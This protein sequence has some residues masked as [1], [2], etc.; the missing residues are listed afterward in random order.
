MAG[1]LA[2]CG[3]GGGSSGNAFTDPG[4][5]IPEAAY[6]ISVELLDA[7][8]L[9]PVQGVNPLE[10]VTVRIVVREKNGSPVASGI[11]SVTTSLGALTP[12]SG[13][14]LTNASGEATIQLASG[15]AAVGSAGTLVVAHDGT[16]TDQEPLEPL[17]FSILPPPLRLGYFANGAFVEGTVEVVAPSLSSSG[18][19][20]LN[21]VVLGPDDQPYEEPLAVNFFSNCSRVNPPLAVLDTPVNTLN[22]LA[23]STYVTQGCEGADTVTAE[24]ALYPDIFATGNL[25][26][27]AATINSIEFVSATPSVIALRGTGGAGR[28]ETSTLVFRV[29]DGDGRI[30]RGV[31]VQFALT[32]DAGGLRLSTPSAVTNAAGNASVLVSSGT[33]ATTVRVKASIDVGAGNVVSTVS[34]ILV[35]STGLPDQD[36][37]SLSATVLN[38]GG[39]SFD[40]ITTTLNIR[41]ADAFNNPVP[42]GTAISFLTEY[43]RIAPSCTTDNGGCSVSWNSQEPRRPVT[44][45]FI[46]DD[47]QS[48]SLRT[49]FNTDCPRPQIPRGVP[50]PLLLGQPYGARSS[51]LVTALG[52]ESYVDANGN[53]QYD[54]GEAFVDLP[55]AILDTNEDGAFGN[56]NAIGSCYP[57][58][59]E[60]AGDE[61][62][63]VDLNGNGAYDTGNG[64]YNGVLCSSQAQAAGAC[65]TDLV[66]VRQQI[67]IIVAGRD[68]YAAFYEGTGFAADLLDGDI[69]V[70]SGTR[71]INFYLSDMYNGV[72]PVGTSVKFE[73]ENCDITPES[74]T[75]PNTNAYGPTIIPVTLSGNGNELEEGLVT[76][77]VTVPTERGGTG[78]GVQFTLMC[79]DNPCGFSPQ[80]DFC[81]EEGE[82]G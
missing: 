67:P 26:V 7:E 1:L 18:S 13:Q 54:Q 40:G 8:T 14:V 61:D 55:E 4:G 42:D 19:T 33:V 53:G 51:I 62:R 24:L 64:I 59:P 79:T 75:V 9:Q 57:N 76:A 23:T 44:Y 36:S 71:Q 22:G 28:S 15:G 56:R 82:G 43:G 46:D 58:C 37:F 32:T 6:Q 11:V 34:D 20:P 5:N 30:A 16:R 70:G 80:P 21:L 25:Q 73:S 52:E 63:F 12:A 39:D 2:A 50:C 69:Y 72:L 10:P 65:S 41:A 74:A 60:E 29:L 45:T 31:T 66:H 49:I 3:G 78:Q 48:A 27:A 77:T 81:T 17:N 68:P 38:P 47:G 35:V